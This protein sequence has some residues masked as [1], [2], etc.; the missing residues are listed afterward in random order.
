MSS[1][2]ASSVKEANRDY[3]I[4]ASIS[5]R[6][7]PRAFADTPVEGDQLRRLFEAARWAPSCFNEQPWSFIVATTNRPKEHERVLRCLTGKN[8]R[9]AYGAP[10]LAI[11]IAGTSFSKS[12]KP[13]RH[14]LHDVGLAMGNLLQQASAEGLYVH[15]MAG[16]D[17]EAVGAEFE[18]PEG[19]EVIAGIAIGYLGDP[20]SLPEEFREKEKAP[21]TRKPLSDFLFGGTFGNRSELLEAE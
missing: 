9:W 8:Q 18:V 6:W 15:Q 10:V 20:E 5:R 1:I 12:G 11:S 3:E 19:Y 4:L 21:R 2:D 16:I 7:S 17:H 13:N 14:A